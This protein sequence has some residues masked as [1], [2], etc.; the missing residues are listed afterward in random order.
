[1]QLKGSHELHEDVVTKVLELILCVTFITEVEVLTVC[2]L[3]QVSNHGLLAAVVACYGFV[4]HG[5]I[6]IF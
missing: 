6:N 3:K 5:S 1:M 4:C 2:A